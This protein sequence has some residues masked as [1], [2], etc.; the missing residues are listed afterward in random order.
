MTTL[1]FSP[2]M[3]VG[4]LLPKLGIPD[5]VEY[6]KCF[7]VICIT[8]TYIE[9][10]LQLHHFIVVQNN[11]RQRWYRYFRRV[12]NGFVVNEY[13]YLILCGDLNARTGFI[14]IISSSK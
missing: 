5:S 9:T 8:E 2:A 11:G 1:E 7:D 6:L 13:F 4:G 3:N 10:N 14:I 12:R